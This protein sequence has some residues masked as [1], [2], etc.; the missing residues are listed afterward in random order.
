MRI[1]LT[2]IIIIACGFFLLFPPFPESYSIKTVF[3]ATEEPVAITQGTYG[4]ALTVNI[5]FGDDEVLNWVQEL[6]KPYPTIFVDTDWAGRFPETIRLIKEKNIPTA[7]LGKNGDDYE[8]SA[9]L[10]LEQIEQFEKIFGVKPLWFRT[11]DEIFSTFLHKVLW[12]AEVNAISSTFQWSGGDIP[13]ATKGEIISV[14]HHRTNRVNLSEINR[15]SET[16]EFQTIEDV[17]FGATVK[18]KKFPK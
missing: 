18:K 11:S 7:L 9:E 3:R 2:I 6:E 14:P 10:L 15:L 4:S 1:K 13:P 16:R 12:E 5:S 8:N 17:L